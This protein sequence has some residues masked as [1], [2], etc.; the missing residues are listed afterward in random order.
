MYGICIHVCAG[1]YAH[2]A[3]TGSL[4]SLSAALPL[5][6]LKQCHSLN[7]EL[8]VSLLLLLLFVCLFV[9]G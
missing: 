6:P 4:T 5:T 8:K 3:K 1:V 7:L 2:G 9:F